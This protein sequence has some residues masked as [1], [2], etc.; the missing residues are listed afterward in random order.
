MDRLVLPTLN[1]TVVLRQLTTEDAPAYFAAVD[2]NREHLSQFGDETAA[3]YPTLES[4]VNSL[5]HPSNPDKVR[6][7]IWDGETFV[8]SVNLTPDED[9]QTSELGYWLDARHMGHA[10]ATLATQALSKYAKTRYLKVYAEVVEGNDKSAKVLERSGFKATAR[11]AGRLTFELVGH[12]PE[13]LGSN[14]DAQAEWLAG[15]MGYSRDKVRGYE[16]KLVRLG[17]RSK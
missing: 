2:A 7:G 3:K 9:G 8:G 12:A 4:V 17:P 10:Y 11:E 1:E 15:E 13:R 14:L 16:E 6:M 5:E